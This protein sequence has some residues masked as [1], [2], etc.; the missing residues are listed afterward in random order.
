EFAVDSMKFIATI[1]YKKEYDVF[2]YQYSKSAT[3]IGANYEEAQSSSLK[4]FVQRLRISLREANESRYWL[5]IMERL[6]LGNDKQRKNLLSEVNEISLMLGAG[7]S[8]MHR[9][10]NN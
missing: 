7:V 2:R 3:S 5:K 10:L 6:K 9:K 1:P 4:E 8:R